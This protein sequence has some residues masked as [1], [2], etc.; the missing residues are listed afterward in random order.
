MKE[1]K[2]KPSKAVDVYTQDIGKL[3]YIYENATSTLLLIAS[4]SFLSSLLYN[5]SYFEKCGALEFLT[6][7]DFND[8]IES[9]LLFLIIIMA[10]LYYAQ[11]FLIDTSGIIGRFKVCRVSQEELIKESDKIDNKFIRAL[12]VILGSVLNFIITLIQLLGVTA[13]YLICAYFALVS[14]YKVVPFTSINNEI[15]FKTVT[16]VPVIFILDILI[17]TR[18]KKYN[19]RKVAMKACLII[20]F[21]SFTLGSYHAA[22]DLT[23]NTSNRT[24]SIKFLRAVNKGAIFL[25][26]QTKTL[27]FRPWNNIKIIRNN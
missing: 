13:P 15:F 12:G 21:I 10:A 18:P 6:L 1:N 26:S 25:N 2:N 9:S 17:S 3:K 4:F 11:I 7:L 22:L 16:L 24:E 23:K 5:F 8:Y 14:Y 19:F 20:L 27:E